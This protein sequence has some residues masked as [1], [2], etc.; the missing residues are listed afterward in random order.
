MSA[1][2]DWEAIEAAYRAG[3]LS[4]REIAKAH[5]I[6][7]G[8]IRKRA[9][10]ECW[11]RALADKVREAVR[12]KLVRS[13]GTQPSRTRT[14]AEIIETSAQIGFDVVTS[15]RRDL[16]QL[17]GLKRVL[18]DRLATHLHGGQPDGPLLGDRE[19]PGDLLEKLSRV[20]A[21]LIPL[22][23]QAHNLDA[24]PAGLEPATRADLRAALDRLDQGQRD[25][26]RAIA[27]R[28][29][30]QPDDPAAGA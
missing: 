1:K 22:E 3:Q 16:Q 9:K 25:Q 7:E 27:E 26:L 18:A 12:E 24:D 28:L 15:H 20:T 19:S 30:G 17:H 13:D 11:T 5:S 14:D 10:A 23:R 21:R 6:S 4:I 29:A 2:T 8:A